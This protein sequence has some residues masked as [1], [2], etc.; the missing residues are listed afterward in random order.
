MTSSMGADARFLPFL[1]LRFEGS[2]TLL[3][4]LLSPVT[5]TELALAYLSLVWIFVD[6]LHQVNPDLGK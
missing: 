4:E 1:C 2:I 3:A 6:L 5:T